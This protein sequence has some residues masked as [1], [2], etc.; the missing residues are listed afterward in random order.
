MPS[1][2][3]QVARPVA[4]LRCQA[5]AAQVVAATK[6]EDSAAAVA[7][8]QFKLRMANGECVIVFA[9]RGR[10]LVGTEAQVQAQRS[11]IEV[12]RA[13]RLHKGR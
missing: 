5:V 11:A 7:L 9:T 13:A 6:G 4:A 1:R 2:S 8:N 12:I 3:A 10:W